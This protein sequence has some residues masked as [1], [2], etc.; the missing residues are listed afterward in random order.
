MPCVHDNS[1]LELMRGIR[2]HLEDLITNLSVADN[3]AM[4]L[5]LAHGLARY[6]LAFSPD[7]VDTM[8]VQ[9]ISL[10]DELDKVK[11]TTDRV[12]VGTRLFSPCS[13]SSSEPI[14]ALPNLYRTHTMHAHTALHRSSTRTRCA[15]ASGTAGTSLKWARS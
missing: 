3:N 12:G 7:K 13:R 11:I 4:K 10:L 1:V 15:C 8:I 9:S 14:A 6:K 2:S 5:G